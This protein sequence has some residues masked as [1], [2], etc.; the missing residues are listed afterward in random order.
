MTTTPPVQHHQ[1]VP[2][3]RVVE[4]TIADKAVVQ[5]LLQLYLH[6]FSEF[7]DRDVDADGLYG[8]RYLDQY[9]IETDR[10]PFLFEVDGRWAG[11]ALVHLGPP[12]DMAEFFVMRRFR[13]LGLGRDAALQLFRRFPGLWQ[14]R[15]L[16]RNPD[17][18][19]FWRSAIPVDYREIENEEGIV[20][21]FVIPQ[22]DG[23]GV[24]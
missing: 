2:N 12:I 19:Y 17:A 13:R 11:F 24:V 15:Q 16:H 4:A 9:W 7:D 23:E 22:H 5:H 10:R 1:P 6:D 3:L 8:Y 14:L 18:T 21:H 20:Q